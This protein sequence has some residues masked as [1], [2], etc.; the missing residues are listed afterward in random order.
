[1]AP[2]CP[3]GLRR[4]EARHGR[5]GVLTLALVG[6][7]RGDQQ[8]VPQDRQEVPVGP[9]LGLISVLVEGK[10]T[11]DLAHLRTGRDVPEAYLRSPP[12]SALLWHT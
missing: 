11:N 10:G 5:G 8:N 9:L 12:N 3:D 1:M 2:H 7:Q 6:R 4:L